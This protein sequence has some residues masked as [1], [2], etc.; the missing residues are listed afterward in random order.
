MKNHASSDQDANLQNQI[1]QLEKRKK[2]LENQ[3][4]ATETAQTNKTDTGYQK[5]GDK[6]KHYAD[7]AKQME[8]LTNDIQKLVKQVAPEE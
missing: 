8:N 6:L 3:V 1:A 4:D 5:A 2:M 7:M